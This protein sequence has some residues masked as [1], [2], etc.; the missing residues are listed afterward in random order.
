MPQIMLKFPKRNYPAGVRKGGNVNPEKK[1][2][3]PQVPGTR[4]RIRPPQATTDPEY[5]E[6]SRRIGWR[7]QPQAKI[8]PQTNREAIAQ[9]L[10]RL[11]GI[12]EGAAAKKGETSN[13][14]TERLRREYQRLYGA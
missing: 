7:D 9:M 3:Q 14:K 11:F 10:G 1:P 13:E 2:V 6:R 4:D 12:H 8:E 5:M